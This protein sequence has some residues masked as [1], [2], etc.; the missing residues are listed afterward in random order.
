[1]PLP[2]NAVTGGRDSPGMP[3]IAGFT[4]SR[5]RS[6]QQLRQRFN[7][8]KAGSSPTTA[9]GAK[10]SSVADVGVVKNFLPLLRP[11]FA[12]RCLCVSFRPLPYNCTWHISLWHHG[13]RITQTFRTPCSAKSK[14]Q[15]VFLYDVPKLVSSLRVVLCK[16]TERGVG[17]VA[18][19]LEHGESTEIPL[20]AKSQSFKEISDFPAGAKCVAVSDILVHRQFEEIKGVQLHDLG[21]SLPSTKTSPEDREIHLLNVG[22]ELRLASL[23]QYLDPQHFISDFENGLGQIMVF[24]HSV[25]RNSI[26]PMKRLLCDMVQEVEPSVLN[27]CSARFLLS[28]GGAY[29]VSNE[30]LRPGTQ[31]VLNGIL[32]DLLSI[33]TSKLA[34]VTSTES[35]FSNLW[36][37]LPPGLLVET[38]HRAY[39]ESKSVFENGLNIVEDHVAKAKLLEKSHYF[40]TLSV[41]LLLGTQ[42][43]QTNPTGDSIQWPMHLQ[44]SLALV[45]PFMKSLLLFLQQ[46]HLHGTGDR[47]NILTS[48]SLILSAAS[49]M[50]Y[51]ERDVLTLLKILPEFSPH[52]DPVHIDACIS[53]FHR[54][55]NQTGTAAVKVI[56]NVT[57]ISVLFLCKLAEK[58]TAEAVKVVELP[59]LTSLMQ[60]TMSIDLVSTA[61]RFFCTSDRFSPAS[62]TLLS[63]IVRTLEQNMTWCFEQCETHDNENMLVYFFDIVCQLFSKYLRGFE[64]HGI[65]SDMFLATCTSPCSS[66]ASDVTV[67][68]EAPK[69][70]KVFLNIAQLFYPSLSLRFIGKE[71]GEYVSSCMLITLLKYANATLPNELEFCKY[72]SLTQS[73]LPGAYA[74]ASEELLGLLVSILKFLLVNPQ[75]F[76]HDRGDQGAKSNKLVNVL[77]CFELLCP[78]HG[79]CIVNEEQA[80]R[81]KVL[82]RLLEPMTIAELVTKLREILGHLDLSQPLHFERLIDTWARQ[83]SF[84]KQN[85]PGVAQKNSDEGSFTSL[86]SILKQREVETV[87]GTAKEALTRLIRVEDSAGKDYWVA[88]TGAEGS[89]IH[90]LVLEGGVA[91][92][93]IAAESPVPIFKRKT[94][95][96]DKGAAGTVIQS[97]PCESIETCSGLSPSN[98]C[99][100]T[101]HANIGFGTNLDDTPSGKPKKH[102]QYGASLADWHLSDCLSD[103]PVASITFK[104]SSVHSAA[105]FFSPSTTSESLEVSSLRIC[106]R[107]ASCVSWMHRKIRLLTERFNS[108]VCDMTLESSLSL[109]KSLFSTIQS[110]EVEVVGFPVALRLIVYFREWEGDLYSKEKKRIKLEYVRAKKVAIAEGNMLPDP[111][112][113]KFSNHLRHNIVM[114]K[115]CDFYNKLHF[116][117]EECIELL[118]AQSYN[119]FPA[120]IPQLQSLASKFSA[121]QSF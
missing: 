118:T 99:T 4:K 34:L 16:E 23:G 31:G 82:G 22:T 69:V 64:S 112:D 84:V 111:A 96:V 3:Q 63:S 50:L 105:A 41:L 13:R 65:A 76:K 28:V 101:C 79:D 48:F 71:N 104:R 72:I 33:A 100:Y 47:S 94:S 49:N 109:F 25:D 45:I 83:G 17:K 26:A 36:G 53:L 87:E 9:K 107:A 102:E 70:G 75:S 58:N 55:L 77:E 116:L 93:I 92:E 59:A 7:K 21:R 114:E 32:V 38:L 29:R 121:L 110:P 95:L 24:K 14:G 6:L 81:R 2:N 85:A 19:F 20:L 119:S 57:E 35:F 42:D 37:T 117:I 120:L 88:C 68:N 60:A 8:R 15:F 91:G 5:E 66:A 1:M 52:L 56:N 67:L 98:G 39:S 108:A 46:S 51:M 106:S 10:E 61:I 90:N 54:V 62:R 78:G 97:F 30:Y 11:L 12:P 74:F 43:D 113:Y 115:L 103:G 44:R 18:R 80:R 73:F 40:H 86:T 27:A 89:Q